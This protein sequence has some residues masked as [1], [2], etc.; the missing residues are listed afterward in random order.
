[1]R[2]R[3]GMSCCFYCSK[4][5]FAT[6]LEH[7]QARASLGQPSTPI[8]VTKTLAGAAFREQ[9]GRLLPPQGH[10]VRM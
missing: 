1:M 9:Q 7:Q 5:H 3:I 10:Q 2:H 8:H 4:N 6:G